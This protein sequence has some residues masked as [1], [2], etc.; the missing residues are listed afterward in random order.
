[1][2]GAV[3]YTSRATNAPRP[4]F[5]Q[6]E[7]LRLERRYALAFGEVAIFYQREPRTLLL[8]C[9]L[10][11]K[12][13]AEWLRTSCLG[14]NRRTMGSFAAVA[15]GAG[16]EAQR[17]PIFSCLLLCGTRA[18]R[19]ALLQAS[20]RERNENYYCHGFQGIDVAV[21][22]AWLGRIGK[23]Q[24]HTYIEAKQY[25]LGLGPFRHISSSLLRDLKSLK[26]C[27]FLL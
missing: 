8:G 20:E 23:H 1:M 6:H 2:L 4:F 12:H 22:W 7:P 3:I 13:P 26:T 27:V 5:L 9:E 19:L 14:R 17:Q 25:Y 24:G 11:P 10:L 15:E 16:T 18:T 21:C